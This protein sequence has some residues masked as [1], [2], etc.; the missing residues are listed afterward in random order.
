MEPEQFRTEFKQWKEEHL[1]PYCKDQCQT[2]CCDLSKSTIELLPD[3][4]VRVFDDNH[5][6]R[7]VGPYAFKF[8]GLCPQYDPEKKICKIYDQR[9]HACRNFPFKINFTDPIT[10][11]IDTYC[12]FS[13]Q[14]KLL[15]DLFKLTVQNE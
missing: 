13:K 14:D 3:E 12:E 6:Y 11:D 15:E 1:N 7:Q 2:N 4:L 9:P 5:G 8:D 10:I